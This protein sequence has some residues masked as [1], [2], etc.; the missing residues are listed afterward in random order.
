[1]QSLGEMPYS[2]RASAMGPTFLCGSRQVPANLVEPG[3]RAVTCRMARRRLIAC[4]ADVAELM[5]VKF[6]KRS[7]GPSAISPFI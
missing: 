3:K 1:M 6:V 4:Q 5:L 7:Q 2:G